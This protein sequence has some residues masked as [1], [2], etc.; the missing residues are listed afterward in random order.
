MNHQEQLLL[1]TTNELL[2]I[3]GTQLGLPF[4]VDLSEE[5]EY[6]VLSIYRRDR[7]L[8]V[9]FYLEYLERDEPTWD[10]DENE[11][12]GDEE[13]PE[14]IENRKKW[15][16]EMLATAQTIQQ[17]EDGR[18]VIAG[19]M[20]AIL[21]SHDVL[22]YQYQKLEDESV[23]LIRE[24]YEMEP[25]DGEVRVPVYFSGKECFRAKHICNLGYARIES[26]HAMYTDDGREV[27]TDVYFPVSVVEAIREIDTEELRK[28]AN[29]KFVVETICYTCTQYFEVIHMEKAFDLFCAAA[30]EVRC[31]LLSFSEFCD[32]TEYLR[33]EMFS[34]FDV[35][36]AD[37]G[38]FVAADFIRDIM[39]DEGLSSVEGFFCFDA[40]IADREYYI[41]SFQELKE[42]YAFG[43]WPSREGY[44]QLKELI[45]AFYEEERIMENNTNS[46]FSMFSGF[47]SKEE[48]ERYYSMDAVDQN[49]EEELFN[50]CS[51]FM[52]NNGVQDVL[53]NNLEHLWAWMNDEAKDKLE[54]YLEMAW[55]NTNM[56]YLK[57]HTP[58]TDED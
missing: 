51:S 40:P 54:K 29:T 12:D 34:C 1:K 15:H 55:E 41:P 46:M 24:A 45:E 58:T 27:I 26:I 3:W 30:K 37:E 10:E 4:P 17:I 13:D 2:E 25:K 16:Y 11:Q 20:S 33:Q 22:V 50:I 56:S 44:R 7:S 38:R 14:I 57:G 48:E 52:G 47:S 36:H 8:D 21:L 31:C 35:I 6:K 42:Y 39:D 19:A 49:V 23:A 28:K 18:E 5:E 53:T 9:D 32:M 43:Y